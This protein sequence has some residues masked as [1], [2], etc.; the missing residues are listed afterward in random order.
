[1]S[2][3]C[4]TND[5]GRATFV[6]Q[7]D[8]YQP[9]T[10]DTA[11]PKPDLTTS[12]DV[13]AADVTREEK[14]NRKALACGTEQDMEIGEAIMGAPCEEHSDC[15]SGFCYDGGFMGWDGGFSFC[16][17]A[18]GD[19]GGGGYECSKFDV[20]DGPRYTCIKLPSCHEGDHPVREFCVSSCQGSNGMA[21]C[22]EW[23]GEGTYQDCQTPSTNACGTIGVN[24]ACFVPE[25]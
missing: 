9:P 1:M 17:R 21:N 13:A 4:V 8:T 18:C 3:G 2:L 25:P 15:E 7:P 5:S 20:E 19:C 12:P 11:Q 10:P 16:T 22:N 24:K 6:P 14:D 23:F